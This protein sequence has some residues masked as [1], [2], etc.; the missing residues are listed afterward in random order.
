MTEARK[1]QIQL[2]LFFISLVIS[3]LIISY[4]WL[5]HRDL[6]QKVEVW[7]MILAIVYTAIELLKK[8][9]LQN[10]SKW[11]RLYYLGLLGII[12]PVALEDKASPETIRWISN[13]GVIFLLAP[14]AIETSTLLKAKQTKKL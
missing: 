9:L 8:N 7:V 1:T 14:L 4:F 12:A 10:P 5:I 3:C 11:N 2:V 6:T 13:I